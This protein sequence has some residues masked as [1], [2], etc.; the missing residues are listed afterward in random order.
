[1]AANTVLV[2]VERA[3]QVMISRGDLVL[4]A[5]D[6]LS[7]FGTDDS[8]V[9][10]EPLFGRHGAGAATRRALPRVSSADPG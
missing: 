9:E 10:L 5:M 3:G 6:H 2:A 7:I 8:T 1:M 4:R